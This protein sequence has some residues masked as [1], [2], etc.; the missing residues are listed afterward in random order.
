MSPDK[1]LNHFSDGSLS[2]PGIFGTTPHNLPV[3]LTTDRSQ[4]TGLY[5]QV[6][7]NRQTL[8]QVQLDS[9]ICVQSYLVGT[10][11]LMET[12]SNVERDDYYRPD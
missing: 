4:T 11:M 12:T 2:M 6:I 7:V 8:I 1:L 10:D 3:G 9:Q 5:G